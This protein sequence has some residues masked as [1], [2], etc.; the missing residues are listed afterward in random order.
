MEL[1]WPKT[2]ASLLQIFGRDELTKA[3]ESQ[4]T[5]PRA[6]NTKDGNNHGFWVYHAEPQSCIGQSFPALPMF[7]PFGM[8]MLTLCHCVSEVCDL[9]FYFRGT[10]SKEIA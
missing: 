10:H 3:V 7:L 9:Y 1:N 6:S 2:E 8:R 4:M 5:P